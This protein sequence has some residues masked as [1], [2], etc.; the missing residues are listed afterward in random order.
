MEWWVVWSRAKGYVLSV[1]AV[2]AVLLLE[3]SLC[4]FYDGGGTTQIFGDMLPPIV[5]TSIFNPGSGGTLP[6]T[7]YWIPYFNPATL[8]GLANELIS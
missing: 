1:S 2:E 6:C 4:D 7:V 3:H 8:K 5:W